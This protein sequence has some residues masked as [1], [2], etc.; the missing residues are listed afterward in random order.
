M[1]LLLKVRTAS[2]A[3]S[4]FYSMSAVF[5]VR[6]K[7]PEHEVSVYFFLVPRLHMSVPIFL[8]PPQYAIVVYI[9]HFFYAKGFS[10][11]NITL[12]SQLGGRPG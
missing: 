2:E 11:Y 5:S 12:G 10:T 6:L 8:L 7:R 1:S 9:G 3:G 4:A